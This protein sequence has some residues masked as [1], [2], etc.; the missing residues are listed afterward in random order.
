MQKTKLLLNI[1]FLGSMLLI[2]FLMTSCQTEEKKPIIDMTPKPMKTVKVPAFNADS[3][4]QFVKDQVDIGPRYPGSEG[5]KT[6]ADYLK[7][8]LEGWAD[9]AMIQETTAVVPTGETVPVYNVIGV[10]NPD[11]K[12][13]ILLSAHW[14]TRP[15]AD[16]DTERVNEPILGANDGGSG[17]GVLL[18]I[19][20]ILHQDKLQKVGVDIILWDVE[21]SGTSAAGSE[22]YCKGSQF[23]ARNPHVPNYK[24]AFGINLDMVGAKDAIFYQEAYSL[25]FASSIVRKVWQAAHMSGHGSHFPFES[26]GGVTDDHVFVNTIAGIPMIDIIQFDSSLSNGFGSFWHTHDDNMDVISKKTLKAVGETV[27]RVVYEEDR[28]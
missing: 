6:C 14:D 16:Q 11:A 28:K 18:E 25:Q 19:A 4:Y 26:T 2:I 15:F 24:A 12:K 9:N 21:D 13:R 10:F 23:W 20:R 1:R 3:A 8:K 27:T 7:G 17:V 5:Q 22:S